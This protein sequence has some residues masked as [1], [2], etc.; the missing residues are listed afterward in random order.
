MVI[1]GDRARDDTRA[2][3]RAARGV[4][5]PHRVLVTAD[6]ASAARASGIAAAL[7]E[8]RGP[9]ADGAPV[10]YVCRNGACGLPVTQPD[11]LIEALRAAVCG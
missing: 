10:G 5:V 2:M 3:L 1:L 6:T 7:V 8:G 9:A 4:M 11:A